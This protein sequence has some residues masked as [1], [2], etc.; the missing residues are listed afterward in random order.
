M[1]GMSISGTTTF[2]LV[3]AF[4]IMIWVLLGIKNVQE[5][6]VRLVERFGKYH[7]T[8]R[9][10][11]NFILPG[12]DTVKTDFDLYTYHEDKQTKNIEKVSVS[13]KPSKGDINVQEQMMDPA[14]FDTIAKDN[15]VVHPDVITYFSI[16][17][18][19]KAVYNVNNLGDSLFKLIE[20]TIRQEI[21]TQSS[22]S[23]VTARQQIGRNVKAAMD[24]ATE[25]WGTRVTRV[26]IQEIKFDQALQDKLVKQ[27][28]AELEKRGEV[29]EAQQEKEV[30]IL[31]AEGIK[32]AEILQAE[33]KKQAQILEAEG[34]FEAKRLEAEANFLLESKQK[35]G[36]AKGMQ[37]ISDSL[38]DQPEALIILDALKAQ[39]KVAQSIG[40]SN[41]ALIIPSETAGLF[42]VI[43]SIKETIGLL[44]NGL[45]E[46]NK[47]GK[48][49]NTKPKPQGDEK[50]L[51]NK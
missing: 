13:H 44:N 18:A 29:V 40:S 24:E 41:N 51:N 20:T 27:R 9:P 42:G 4:F 22:D 8:L 2:W 32:Q 14:P 17:D 39:G 36:E 19:H 11:I 7:K 15:A 37:A 31:K 33:G 10:G 5:G 26:E 12:I 45:I 49:E 50:K 43:G 34:V 46:T 6:Y 3:F 23:L 16:I 38:K 28:K 1:S 30:R 25:G 35:E 21:G 47:N 48:K